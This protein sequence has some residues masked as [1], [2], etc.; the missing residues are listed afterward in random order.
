MWTKE[1]VAEILREGIVDIQ[2]IKKDG[3]LREMRCTLNEEYL[4][5][6]EATSTKKENP[7]VL[8]VWDIDNNGWRSFIV[9]Q[10]VWVG[11]H[12]D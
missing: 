12:N 10:L 5:K 3:S 4:P 11:K 1:S 9:K 6:A 7:D 2:F 8:S